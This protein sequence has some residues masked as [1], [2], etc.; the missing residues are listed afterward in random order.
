[1]ITLAGITILTKYSSFQKLQNVVSYCLR[2]IYNTKNKDKF[3]KQRGPLSQTERN[4]SLHMIL[5]LTQAEAFTSEI[6]LI[7][8]IN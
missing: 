2:F 8:E 5:K 7:K 3:S 4:S 1:M 6:K